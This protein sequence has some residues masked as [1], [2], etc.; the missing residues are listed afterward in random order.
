MHERY[1]SP[2]WVEAEGFFAYREVCYPFQN[3]GSFALVIVLFGS[4]VGSRTESGGLHDLLWG[5][6]GKDHQTCDP[7]R[8]LRPATQT[9]FGRTC[10]ITQAGARAQNTTDRT[11]LPSLL[12]QCTCVLVCMAEDPVI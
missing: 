1:C 7:S 4:V 8:R 10:D 2:V 3:K 11:D 6:K 12:G 9:K 5:V